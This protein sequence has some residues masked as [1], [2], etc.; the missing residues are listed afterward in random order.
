MAVNFVPGEKRDEGYR[1]LADLGISIQGQDA[2]GA[3]RGICHIVQ[4]LECALTVKFA[5]REKEG[6]AFPGETGHFV[7]AGK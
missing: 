2:N 7:I 3:W 6:A 5:W 1:P 4:R